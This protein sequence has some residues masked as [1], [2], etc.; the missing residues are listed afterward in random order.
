MT[1]RIEDGPEGWF[2]AS[3]R[4][5]R[6]LG[7]VLW[8]LAPEIA[9]GVI[10]A[11]TGLV[12]GLTLGAGLGAQLLEGGAW[13]RAGPAALIFPV[14]A[15]LGPALVLAFVGATAAP[16]LVLAVHT[17]VVALS[18]SPERRRSRPIV[19]ATATGVFAPALVMGVVWKAPLAAALVGLFLAPITGTF[20]VLV[21]TSWLAIRS[22]LE[23]RSLAAWWAQ[24]DTTMGIAML[25]LSLF[26]WLGIWVPFA[27]FFVFPAVVLALVGALLLGARL[28]WAGER[29]GLV[30]GVLVVDLLHAGLLGWA[31]FRSFG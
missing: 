26:A 3:F 1:P 8:T 4:A 24:A 13:G 17:V 12:I 15:F 28:L 11:I 10:G 30:A 2:G 14:L 20:G 5:L 6:G 16:S 7:R 27:I 21:G 22:L 25:T 31:T 19:F 18:K 23:G 29:R 9:S